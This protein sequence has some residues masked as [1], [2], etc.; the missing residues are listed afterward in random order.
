MVSP[1]CDGPTFVQD[2]RD[3]KGLVVMEAERP[4]SSNAST[5]AGHSANVDWWEFTLNTASN[6]GYVKVPT[7]NQNTTT[8][9]YD[10]ARLD[11]EIEFTQTGTHYFEL[12]YWAP[13]G[14][15][16]SVHL[17]LDGVPI[18]AD[19]SLVHSR[20]DW[21][22][23]RA[24]NSFTIDTPGTHTITVFHREDGVYLDKIGITTDIDYHFSG[25]GPEVTEVGTTHFKAKA[26]DQRIG[27]HEDNRTGRG[28]TAMEAEAATNHVYG[29]GK[30]DC[31]HWDEVADETASGGT[32]MVTEEQG[33]RTDTADVWSAP[34][35]DFEIELT[36]LD[37][38]YI[39]IRHRGTYD[40]NS[41]WVAIDYQFVSEWHISKSTT[42]WTW[43][44]PNVGFV[45]NRKGVYLL[46]IIMREDATPIDKIIITT[47]RKFYPE[48]RTQLTTEV[49][50]PNL[51]Y[52][53]QEDGIVELPLEKP[54]R[55]LAGLKSR[56]G[57]R[58]LVLDDPAAE[59]GKYVSVPNKLPRQINLQDS[60]SR[61]APL[62][63]Y[64]IDFTEIGPHFLY[65][66]H[67]S[68]NNED[69]SYSFFL[70]G[71]KI[72]E[73]H[74]NQL[75]SDAWVYHEELPSF[76]V[77]AAGRHTLSIYMRED[78]TP[79]DHLII[80]NNPALNAAAMPIELTDLDAV[81]RSD[82]N[83][84]TF[85]SVYEDN[86]D[87]HLIERSSDGRADWQ[88]VGTLAAAG[89]SSSALAYRF[90]DTNPTT[91]AYYR[92]TT[93]DLDGSRSTSAIIAVVREVKTGDLSVSVYPNP[94]S[95]FATLRYTH[96]EGGA[97]AITVYDLSGAMVATRNTTAI[98]GVNELDVPLDR[99]G[100][101]T[102]VI[103]ANL[104]AGGVVTQ[105]LVVQH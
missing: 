85:T 68:P 90:T 59:D 86:T 91:R 84:V 28:V 52:T 9:P 33:Q 92:V 104:G 8:V 76:E 29:R 60:F 53:Q 31:R 24:N 80:S 46:S 87:H 65:M 64:D 99:L 13:S 51:T 2:D 74:I 54:S 69:N 35:L 7:T 1:G 103:A 72:E 12:R 83:L 70:D 38:H 26:A 20:N 102:Y 58:W 4:T 18:E 57:L 82:D 27:Y 96:P 42:G 77:A 56:S 62:L 50:P 43:E 89:N 93:V 67:R 40:N 49:V 48:T 15:D 66:R 45:N 16:N 78:G 23:S 95:D 73:V 105:R 11:F 47:D 100:N 34:R 5:H 10:G 71:V 39:Y 44:T 3:G 21:Y 97:V 17:A 63:E 94:A 98:S 81:A 88:T 32:Y 37:T 22:W 30:Y 41:V 14:N 36:E 55:N 101:G 6:G 25:F 61:E 19:W 79:L 75:S